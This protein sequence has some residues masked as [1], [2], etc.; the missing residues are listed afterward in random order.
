M[1]EAP[2]RIRDDIEA[3]RSDLARDVDALADRTVPTRVARRRWDELKGKVRGVSESV[4][5]APGNGGRAVKD[6]T[7]SAVGTVQEAASQAGDKAADV[8]GNVADTVRQAPGTIAEK[9]KGNPIAAG[10][11]AFGVGL[12]TASLIPASE[13]ERKAGE[14]I[15]ENADDLLEPV[16]EPLAQSGQQL[17]EDLTGS[18][19]AAAEEVKETAK[20]AARATKDQA[21]S[22]AQDAKERTT[23]AVDEARA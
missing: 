23:R 15:R 11:I 6:R 21:T 13:V 2:D 20:D 14:K 4:M 16:R 22:S 17:K 5:G 10:I 18:V 8:A 3:T 9:A 12:L 1:A 7:R 19:T